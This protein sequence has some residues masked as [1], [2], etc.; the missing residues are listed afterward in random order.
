MTAREPVLFGGTVLNPRDLVEQGIVTGVQESCISGNS[1]DLCIKEVFEITQGIVLHKDGSRRLPD[2]HRATTVA[3][4]LHKDGVGRDYWQFVSGKLY[5]VEFTE[6]VSLPP[7]IAGITLMRSSMF[8]SGAAGE[9]GLFDSGYTGGT[10]MSVSVKFTSM[11]EVGAP[12]AQMIFLRSDAS[13][14]Y[15]GYYQTND[16]MRVTQ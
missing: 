14:S 7:D 5:Q 6:Q 1:I 9:P 8:K 12:I 10:G 16:W 2:Y 3:R 4:S 11:V 13:K 15:N